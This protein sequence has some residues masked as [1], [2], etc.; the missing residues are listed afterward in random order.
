MGEFVWLF[1]NASVI[2]RSRIGN[3]VFLAANSLVKD[4]DVP[5]NTVLGASPHLTLK[6]KPSDYFLARSPFR[7]H[8]TGRRRLTLQGR[9]M[10]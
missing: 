9:I 8:Q 1:A 7:A 4:E 5:D 10:G 2:G 3:N 6:H